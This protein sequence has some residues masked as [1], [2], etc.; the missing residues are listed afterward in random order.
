MTSLEKMDET[1]N[2]IRFLTER[3]MQHK[4]LLEL[5]ASTN[6]ELGELSRELKIQYKIFGN[7]YK[8][9]DEGVASEAVDCLIC[10][11]CMSFAIFGEALVNSYDLV[12]MIESFLQKEKTKQLAFKY[13]MK[14]S[15]SIG[16]VSSYVEDWENNYVQPLSDVE[17][18]I[19]NSIALAFFDS[20]VHYGTFDQV[21]DAINHKLDKWEKVGKL[22]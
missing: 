15:S 17:S 7:E 6:E 9:K 16:F 8:T 21:I 14:L 18:T 22:G 20:E 1:L 19:E 12:E 3:D 5:H 13:L 10:G 4:S 2:R 11:Y